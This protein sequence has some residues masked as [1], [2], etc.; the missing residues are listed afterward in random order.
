MGCVIILSAVPVYF[1]CVYWRNKPRLFRLW[2]SELQLSL[3]LS[4]S[5]IFADSVTV[6]LQKVLVVVAPG[7]ED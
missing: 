2:T 6:F 5:Q 7:K 4:L 1:L 3:G